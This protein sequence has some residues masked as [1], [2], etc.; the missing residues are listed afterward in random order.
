MRQSAD[1]RVSMKTWEYRVVRGGRRRSGVQG[2]CDELGAEG[3]ELAG[4]SPTLVQY[5]Q[6]G[7]G[8]KETSADW[9]MIF[10]RQVE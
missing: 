10:K 1:E 2:T 9:F 4:I 7:M 6:G 8:I 3:W 5:D